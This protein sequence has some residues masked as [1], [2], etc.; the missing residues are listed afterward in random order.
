MTTQR[1][2]AV[3]IVGGSIVFLVGAAIGVPRVFTERDPDTRLRLL[4]DGLTR[5]QVAQPLYALG[6]ILVAVGVGV[7]A[8]AAHGSGARAALMTSAIALLAGALPWAWL[9]IER[10]RRV[11]EFVAGAL[12]AWPFTTY[13]L[14]TI[15]G[16]GTLAAG[17]FLTDFP[18][19]VAWLT[20]GADTLFLVAFLRFGDIPP[21]VFYLLLPVIGVVGWRSAGPS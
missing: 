9:A 19:W 1:L 11:T 12:P 14:L 4:Q 15:G 2:A 17:L 5:W 10:G 18:S 20:A 7:L 16:L 3:L 6:P 21:F 8:A 13:V